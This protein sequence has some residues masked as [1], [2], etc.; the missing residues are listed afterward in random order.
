MVMSLVP[1][2]QEDGNNRLIP[3]QKSLV[4]LR[5]FFVSTRNEKNIPHSFYRFNRL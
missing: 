4:A 2:W 5:G 1:Q 3:R